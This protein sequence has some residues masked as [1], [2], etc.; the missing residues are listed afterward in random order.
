MKLPKDNVQHQSNITLIYEYAEKAIKDL[1]GSIDGINTKLSAVIGFNAVLIRFSSSLPDKSFKIDIAILG[2]IMSCYPGLILKIVSCILLIVSIII[3]LIALFPKSTGT[4][5]QPS[6]LIEK[7]LKI[8]EEDYRLSIITLWDKDIEEFDLR[9]KSK[10]K[11]LKV[12][13]ICLGFATILSGLDIILASLFKS[14]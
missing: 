7:C 1:Q 13:V 14:N 8:S 11:S 9:R 10:S 3:S 5:V 4:I 6:E 12:A 2:V